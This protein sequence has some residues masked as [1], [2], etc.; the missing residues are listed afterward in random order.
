MGNKDTSALNGT[1][2]APAQFGGKPAPIVGDTSSQL[3]AIQAVSSAGSKPS[4]NAS[5]A[6]TSALH[7]SVALLAVALVILW[8][9]GGIVFKNANI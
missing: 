7:L 5:A 2:N 9:L 4:N 3:G 8:S 1:L 6:A